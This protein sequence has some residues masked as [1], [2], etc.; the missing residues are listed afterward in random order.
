MAEKE[1]TLDTEGQSGTNT[2]VPTPRYSTE[3]EKGQA[4]DKEV[5]PSQE[6]SA[7]KPQDLTRIDSADYPSSWR[8]FMIVVALV[9]TVILVALDM[10]IVSTAI[11]RITDQ[12]RE[13]ISRGQGS[14]C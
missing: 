12:F 1:T 7:E 6:V 13:W 14:L 5:E 10:T 3:N 11:P 2:A 9:L 8:L 4:I